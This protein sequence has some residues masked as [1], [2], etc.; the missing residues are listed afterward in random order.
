M[1]VLDDKGIVQYPVGGSR[2]DLRSG[3]PAGA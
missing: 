1:T 2:E 3:K